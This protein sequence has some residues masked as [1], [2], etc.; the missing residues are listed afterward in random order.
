MTYRLK[1]VNQRKRVAVSVG[2]GGDLSSSPEI[3][4]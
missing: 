2:V 3:C 1:N 4:P